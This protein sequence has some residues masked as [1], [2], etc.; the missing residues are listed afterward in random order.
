MVSELPSE[1]IA[2]IL[3][4]AYYLKDKPA[5][6]NIFLTRDPDRHTLAACC[7]VNSTW[8]AVAQPLLF[9]HITV[10]V[11]LQFSRWLRYTQNISKGLLES[12]RTLELRLNPVA[13][14][15]QVITHKATKVPSCTLDDFCLLLSSL[16]CLYELEISFQGHSIESPKVSCQSLRALR[17]NECSVQSPVVYELLSLF[18]GVRFL[19]LAVEIAAPPPPNMVPNLK[20]YELVI[21]RTLLPEITEWLVANSVGTL[22]VLELREF[23]GVQMSV[24]LRDH[25]THLQS[26]RLLRLDK[27]S[28]NL[29]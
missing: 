24:V 10:G 12:V 3:G 26:L 9:H 23:V 22:R 27:S 7:R 11:S 21:Y 13:R 16:P 1:L 6:G 5:S 20:L 29:I 25:Y 17:I 28:L 14:Q 8:R 4:E 15:F 19:A 18:P 2:L